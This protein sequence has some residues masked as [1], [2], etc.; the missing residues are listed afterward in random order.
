MNGGRKEQTLNEPHIVESNFLQRK[1]SSLLAT[2]TP[3]KEVGFSFK[4]G[5]NW[6]DYLD[7]RPVYPPP[8]FELIYSYR[9]GKLGSSWSEA[10]DI[11]AGCGFVSA[12]LAAKFPSVIVSD[13]NDGYGTLARSLLEKD[14][15]SSEASFRFL[16]EGAKESSVQTGT[17]DVAVAAECIQWNHTAVAIRE[18]G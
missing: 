11:G 2:T 5:V 8:F 3:A 13:P 1:M 15:A 17:I 9:A 4:Q 18:I 14:P 7:Y 6:S 10:H 12:G 16:Q